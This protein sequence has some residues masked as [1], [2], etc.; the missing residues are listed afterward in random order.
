MTPYDYYGSIAVNPNGDY[1]Y[2]ADGQLQGGIA[3]ISTA[4]NQVVD[5]IVTAGRRVAVHPLGNR[6]YVGDCGGLG[7][8]KVITVPANNIV[9]QQPLYGAPCGIGMLP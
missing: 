5:T 7:G 3:V 1:V 2:V 4:T 8:F 9:S 6:L